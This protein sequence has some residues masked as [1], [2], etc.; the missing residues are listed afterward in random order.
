M[1]L[2]RYIPAS[3]KYPLIALYILSRLLLKG[4]AAQETKL[5]LAGVLPPPDSQKIIHG[6]KVKLIALRERFGD[7]WKGFNTAYF[8]SS[9][10]PFAPAMWLRLYKLFG[11]KTLWNQNG[12]AYP[13]WAKERTDAVNGLLK[14]IHLADYVVYQT[15]FTKR[16]TEKFLG[17]YTGPYT[18]LINPVDTKKFRPREAPLHAEPFIIIMSGHHFESPERLQVSLD[19]VR[20]VRKRGIDA[21]LLVVGNTQEL[22]QETWI[23][24]VGKF[25]QDEAPGLYHRGHI[26]LHLKNLDPCPTFVLEA[27]SSGLPVIGLGNGGMPEMV[28]AKSGILIPAVED[29]QKFAY[30]SAS[31]VSEAILKAKSDLKVLSTGA[32][33]QALK[34]DKELWLKK[35][36]EIFD[37][38]CQKSQ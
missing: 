23:E 25:T 9:G 20:E 37:Q 27:L 21:K 29:F 17:F 33:R 22:P 3:I 30:P 8:V 38:L 36:Q 15:E 24:V 12:L 13:A 16:C 2:K 1:S 19:A 4:R 28:D 35:H 5:N 11:I 14:A 6:G 32:R 10:L 34:F 26:L 31:E 18:V 7:T